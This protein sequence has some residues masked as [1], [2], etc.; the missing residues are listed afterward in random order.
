[1]NDELYDA[2]ERWRAEHPEATWWDTWVAIDNPYRS[3]KLLN[4]AYGR[5]K[6]KRRE[7]AAAGPKDR[8]NN[9]PIGR[10]QLKPAPEDVSGWPAWAVRVRDAIREHPRRTWDDLVVACRVPYSKGCN[11]AEAYRRW[12]YGGA[13]RSREHGDER[14]QARARAD[15]ARWRRDQQMQRSAAMCVA[16][17]ADAPAHP[18][19]RWTCGKCGGGAVEVLAGEPAGGREAGER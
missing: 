3:H 17:G 16:C 4:S 1:M 8:T 11:L 14:I 19:A 2:I 6:K 15:M 7:P 12:V 5:R 10:G 9:L 13:N 18:P